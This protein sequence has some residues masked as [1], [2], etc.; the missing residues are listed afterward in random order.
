VEIVCSVDE[1]PTSL[2]DLLVAV[3]V[4]G[5]IDDSESPTSHHDSLGVVVGLE[6]RWLH[7]SRARLG[8]GQPIFPGH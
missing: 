1:P 8:Q 2:C 3:E 4:V 6:G 7:C 5:S